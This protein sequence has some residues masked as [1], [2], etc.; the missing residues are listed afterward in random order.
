MKKEKTRI[1]ERNKKNRL[2]GKRFEE[3]VRK[4]LKNN[5]NGI[6]IPKGKYTDFILITTNSF[7]LIEVKNLRRKIKGKTLNS[8]LNK[9]DKK[10]KEILEKPK[11]KEIS[12]NKEVFK[13]LV[14]KNSIKKKYTQNRKLIMNFTEFREFFKNEK[15]IRKKIGKET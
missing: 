9:L 14:S 12:K 15:E 7:Y 6:T 4:F 10:T 1:A 2:K 11:W 5:T 8:Y 13:I 3:E